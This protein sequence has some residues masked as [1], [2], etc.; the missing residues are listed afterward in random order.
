MVS[1]VRIDTNPQKTLLVVPAVF[2]VLAMIAV[3][4]RFR[5]R[6]W[7]KQRLLLDDWLCLFGLV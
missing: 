5:T 3:I 4:L 7:K 2:L 1:P 6:A